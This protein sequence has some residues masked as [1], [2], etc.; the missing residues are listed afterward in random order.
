MEP[1]YIKVIEYNKEIYR[2][3][4]FIINDF[5][6]NYELKNDDINRWFKIK[7]II[8]KESVGKIAK[9]FNLHPLVEEDIIET[10]QRSKIEDYDNYSFIITK[11]IYFEDDQLIHDQ[12]NIIFGKN[13][14]I[15]FE[16]SENNYDSL[17]KMNIRLESRGTIL[18]KSGVD[19]LLYYILDS[20]VDGYFDT[21]EI[22]GEKIDI[23]EEKL[24]LKASREGLEDIR[25]LKKEILYIHRHTW[26]LR[27]IT[28]S[29]SR[30]SSSL[31][32]ESTNIY[33]RDVYNHVIQIID[34]T[35]TYRELLSGLIDLNLSSISYSLNE[36]M[37]VLTVIS[38]VFI[39]ITFITGFFG[40]NFKKMGILNSR[41]GYISI[42][43]VMI[44]IVS[45]M[46]YYFKKKK[47]L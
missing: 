24:L 46:I 12:L 40:M 42:L 15:T 9:M 18:R 13:F 8:S 19:Y 34:T 35:Q 27:E 47:W 16:E 43:L 3:K 32:S 38:T 10:N 37:R 17:S 5:I 14:I 36:V 30:G 1:E 41:L 4:S 33:L 6:E 22:M 45:S 29:L 20:I 25:I 2:E 39:P 31:V 7:D 11:L 28:S 21:L 44:F 23:L 26:P